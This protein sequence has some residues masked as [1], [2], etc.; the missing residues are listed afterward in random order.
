[1]LTFSIVYFQWDPILSSKKLDILSDEESDCNCNASI[2]YVRDGS[3]FKTA[4]GNIELKSGGRY[5]FQV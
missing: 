1:M 2:V 5:F 4:F 3:G